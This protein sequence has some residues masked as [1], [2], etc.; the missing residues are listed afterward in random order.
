MFAALLNTPGLQGKYDVETA[1]L[2]TPQ[3]GH[4]CEDEEMVETNTTGLQM[5]Y[6][7][8]NVFYSPHQ[9]FICPTA[10]DKD[11]QLA[12]YQANFCPSV[13]SRVLTLKSNGINSHSNQSSWRIFSLNYGYQFTKQAMDQVHQQWLCDINSR[14]QLFNKHNGKYAEYPNFIGVLKHFSKLKHMSLFVHLNLNLPHFQL[15]DVDIRSKEELMCSSG[16]ILAILS[17]RSTQK[18]ND[19]KTITKRRKLDIK[20]FANKHLHSMEEA[21]LGTLLFWFN[22]IIPH[23]VKK[24]NDY[25]QAQFPLYCGRNSHSVCNFIHIILALILARTPFTYSCYLCIF[26]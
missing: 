5:A 20:L 19:G 25:Q 3:E 8:D 12:F 14:K 23:C 11:K 16:A 10:E 6:F 24:V 9:T 21:R 1:M 7:G 13:I 18:S 2:A 15:Q 4:L 22:E 17:N 26:E